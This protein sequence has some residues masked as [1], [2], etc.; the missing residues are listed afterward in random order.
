MY[1]SG[2]R[3]AKQAAAMLRKRGGADGASKAC[4]TLVLVSTI[5][6]GINFKHVSVGCLADITSNEG[7]FGR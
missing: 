5:S 2:V 7:G 3:L 6:I 4:A 1:A